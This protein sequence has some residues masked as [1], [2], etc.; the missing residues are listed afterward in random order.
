MNRNIKNPKP[1]TLPVVRCAVYTRK[2]TQEGLEQEFNLLDAQRLLPPLGVR[3]ARLPA[4]DRRAADQRPLEDR[5]TTVP[6]SL[7]R[8]PV[9]RH[10]VVEPGPNDVVGIC[11][12]T[13]DRIVLTRDDL[14]VYE[15]DWPLSLAD[16]AAV[17][18]F[19]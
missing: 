5:E 8:A 3:R 7:R 12:E 4:G 9:R 11:P 2:F 19:E 13:E 6:Y 15:L 10:E 18:G 17:L 16:I 14:I 1:A